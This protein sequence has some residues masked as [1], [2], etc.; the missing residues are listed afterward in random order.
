MKYLLI[1]TIL[2]FVGALLYLRARPYIATARRVFGFLRDARRL[3]SDDPFVT[4][5]Q[6]TTRAGE[7]LL[8]CSTC[9]TWLPASR[10]ISH[11]NSATVFCSHACLENAADARQP[12]RKSAS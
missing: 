7:K 9:G 6:R 4:P 1:F 12:R 2:A 8:R 5:T 11:R 3:A 10:A